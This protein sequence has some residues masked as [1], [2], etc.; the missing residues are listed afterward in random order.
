MCVGHNPLL[1]STLRWDHAAHQQLCPPVFC[2]QNGRTW[3]AGGH[4]S[5]CDNHTQP[6]RRQ[7]PPGDVAGD[8]KRVRAR[9]CTLDTTCGKEDVLEH[10]PLVRVLLDVC[11]DDILFFNFPRLLTRLVIVLLSRTLL[12]SCLQ[13]S[14]LPKEPFQN[15]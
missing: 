15:Q 13:L 9:Q 1:I 7:S 4:S 6:F 8:E 10:V 5:E 2:N 3:L 14:S 12:L 11:R